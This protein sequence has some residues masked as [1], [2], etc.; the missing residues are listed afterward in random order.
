MWLVQCL[1][2][3][4][5]PCQQLI[6]HNFVVKHTLTLEKYTN[7]KNIVEYQHSPILFSQPHIACFEDNVHY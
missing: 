6:I 4:S 7:I 1:Q 3:N 2:C 5:S